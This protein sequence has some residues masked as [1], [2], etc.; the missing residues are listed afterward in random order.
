[1]GVRHRFVALAALLCF[2]P[3]VAGEPQQYPLPGREHEEQEPK[4]PSGKSQREE[5]LK[6][7]HEDTV[8]DVDRIRKLAENLQGDLKKN[9]YHVLSIASLKKV[10]EIEKLARRVR[11]R[12][13]H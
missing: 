13:K 3:A 10:E 11:G 9:D 4:L 6:A 5:I 8:A 7:E 2:W 1:M 12:M